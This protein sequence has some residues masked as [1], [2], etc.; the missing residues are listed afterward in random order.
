M[1]KKASNIVM[2]DFA[3]KEMHPFVS[4]LSVAHRVHILL[5]PRVHN[6]LIILLP[7]CVRR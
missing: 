2:V 4:A 3:E 1:I 7:L 5:F 6:I